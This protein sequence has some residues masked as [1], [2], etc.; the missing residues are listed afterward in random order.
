RPSPARALHQCRTGEEIAVTKSCLP[1]LQIRVAR[2]PGPVQTDHQRILLGGTI[3]GRNIE[4]IPVGSLAHPNS[5]TGLHTDRVF[6]RGWSLPKNS[7]Y[8]H[9]GRALIREDRCEEGFHIWGISVQIVVD[10]VGERLARSGFADGLLKRGVAGRGQGTDDQDE[11][12]KPR[13]YLL[14]PQRHAVPTA[15]GTIP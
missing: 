1:A 13:R 7:F 11:Q 6:P 15:S 3:R 5:L 9:L 12:A 4:S 2:K 10:Q 8:F 14:P